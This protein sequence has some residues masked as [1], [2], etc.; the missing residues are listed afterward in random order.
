MRIGIDIDGVLI[1]IEQ[2]IA[3]YGTKFCVENNIEINIEPKCYDEDEAFGWTEEQTLKFWNEYLV[4]YASKYPTREFAKEVIQ[5]LKK[6][7]H[8]IYIVTA[9]NDNGLPKN[10]YGKMKQLVEEWLKVNEIYYDRIIYTE[11][12]KLKYCVGNYIELMI[13]DRPEN[14]KEIATKLPVLCFNAKYNEQ[15]KGKN[16]TRVYS[17][18]D[19]YNKI[20]KIIKDNERKKYDF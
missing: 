6:E 15:I 19:I 13:E 17:W 8:G 5:K 14:V 2:F 16:I 18:Y 11:E 10:Y 20:E 3:D 7:G 4:Y 1:D 9:R 12:S